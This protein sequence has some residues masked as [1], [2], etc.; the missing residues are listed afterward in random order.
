MN[1]CVH[2]GNNCDPACPFC[3]VVERGKEIET[4]KQALRDCVTASLHTGTDEEI[5]RIFAKAI[6]EEA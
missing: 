4:L 3:A 5:A 2:H 6:P 1:A